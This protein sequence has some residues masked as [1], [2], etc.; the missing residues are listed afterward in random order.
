MRSILLLLLPAA[1]FGAIYDWSCNLYCFNEGQCAFGKGHFG[2]YGNVDADGN[3]KDANLNEDKSWEDK[4]HAG[5]MYCICPPGFVGLQCEIS[6]T[7]CGL[8][9]DNNDRSYKCRNGSDCLKQK[10][11][12]GRFFYH[13]E[14]TAD[15]V[16]QAPYVTEYCDRIGTVHCGNNPNEDSFSNSQYCSNGGTCKAPDGDGTKHP[17]CDCTEGWEGRHCTEKKLTLVEEAKEKAW[18]AASAQNVVGFVFL[19]LFLVGS[20]FGGYKYCK[21]R[22]IRKRRRREAEEMVEF[23]TGLIRPKQKGQKLKGGRRPSRPGGKPL[24]RKMRPSAAT[25][26]A[27]ADLGPPEHDVV[28]LTAFRDEADTGTPEPNE[29]I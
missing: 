13:C 28:G 10:D 16:Y 12:E 14:C 29:I 21:R 5:G 15:T 7:M 3:G 19:A 26:A 17:G 9:S 24:G 2:S 18:E 8:L 23:G 25:A 27:P 20:V 11:H 22:R 1:S 6:L 4:D